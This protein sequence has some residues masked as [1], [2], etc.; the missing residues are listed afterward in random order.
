MPKVR[1]VG[2][3]QSIETVLDGVEWVVAH[4][5]SVEVSPEQADRLDSVNWK[6]IDSRPPSKEK[7]ENP[8]KTKEGD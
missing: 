6:V 2:P 4:G 7:A 1:Y 8:P 5:E 3:I